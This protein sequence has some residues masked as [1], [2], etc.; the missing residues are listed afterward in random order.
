MGHII[1]KIILYLAIT[2]LPEDYHNCKN[3]CEQ[4]DK[5][6]NDGW[7]HKAYTRE[8]VIIHFW[9]M[10]LNN[11]HSIHRVITKKNLGVGV[12]FTITYIIW[13]TVNFSSILCRNSK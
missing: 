11:P 1:N 7:D 3:E 10:Y 13:A 5:S 6:K 8:D 9:E 2:F 4:K 12:F